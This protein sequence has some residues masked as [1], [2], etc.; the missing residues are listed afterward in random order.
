VHRPGRDLDWDPCPDGGLPRRILPLAGGQDLAH[1]DLGDPGRFDAGPLQGGL[2]GDAA[3]LMGRQVAE[4]TIEG[5][6]SRSGRPN[7]DDVVWHY[8]PPVQ[9]KRDGR[10]WSCNCS[11]IRMTAWSMPRCQSARVSL[12]CHSPQAGRAR[13]GASLAITLDGQAAPALRN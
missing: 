13:E 8:N 4:S 2:D 7:D 10:D 1:D 11:S 12:F 3:K 9:P 5:P 6:D